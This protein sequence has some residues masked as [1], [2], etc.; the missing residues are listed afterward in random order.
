VRQTSYRPGDLGYVETG[1]LEILQQEI[2]E[3]EKL[4]KGLIK[5]LERKALVPLNPWTLYFN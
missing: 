1:K 2:G 4:L 5:L 3:V